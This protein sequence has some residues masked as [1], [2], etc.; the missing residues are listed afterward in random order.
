MAVVVRHSKDVAAM[1]ATGHKQAS[2]HVRAM[3]ALPSKADIT[4]YFWDLSFVPKGDIP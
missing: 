2:Q 4:K 3:S 1:S